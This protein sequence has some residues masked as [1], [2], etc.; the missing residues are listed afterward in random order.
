MG[1][2]TQRD[3]WAAEA[4]KVRHD[5]ERLRRAAIKADDDLAAACLI[6]RARELE[7]LATILDARARRRIRWCAAGDGEP[8]R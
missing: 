4:S 8:K 7:A 5:A 1:H 2:H 6:A 3:E